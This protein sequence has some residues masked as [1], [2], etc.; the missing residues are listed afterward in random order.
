MDDKTKIKA[1]LQYTTDRIRRL[2]LSPK[3]ANAFIPAVEAYQSEQPEAQEGT[4]MYRA[5]LDLEPLKHRKYTQ[6]CFFCSMIHQLQNDCI[7]CIALTFLTSLTCQPHMCTRT[8]ELLAGHSKVISSSRT[9]G[10]PRRRGCANGVV[11]SMSR[12]SGDLGS[13]LKLRPFQCCKHHRTC[14]CAP[15]GSGSPH[16]F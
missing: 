5:V 12:S 9:G 8:H 3:A 14:K 13:S 15:Q 2:L 7:P 11:G 4:K 6:R 16:G 1:T 10:R